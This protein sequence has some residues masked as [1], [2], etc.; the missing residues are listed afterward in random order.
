MDKN[1]ERKLEILSRIDDDIIE[2]QTKQRIFLMSGRK[3]KKSPKK[4][5]ITGGALAAAAAIILAM[6]LILVP[7]L[8]K[9]VPIYTGMTV[10]GELTAGQAS[11]GNV[12]VLELNG[13]GSGAQHKGHYQGDFNYDRGDLSN[14][15]DKPLSDT[16]NVVGGGEERYYAKPGEDIYITVHIDN[17][18]NFEILS[19]TLNGQKYSSYMFEEG[20][21]MENLILKVNVGNAEGVVEY[22]IDAIKYVDGNEIKDVRM[23]GDRTVE[24]GVYTENQPTAAVSAESIAYNS[25]SFT[26][27]ATDLMDL[28]KDSDG[29]L[30]AVLYDGNSI[31]A[32]QAIAAKGETRITFDGLGTNTLY[33]YAILATYDALDGQGISTYILA[34]KA[35]YTKAVVLFDHISLSTTGVNFAL[36]WDSAIT[37]QSLLDLSIYRGNTKVGIL[38]TSATTVSDLI[39]DTAYT[40]VATY[41]NG[42]GTETIRLE[43][44]TDP[45]TYT[46]NHLKEKLDGTYELVSTATDVIA[47]GAD[48]T[49]AVNAYTGFTSPATQTVTGSTEVALEVN[50]YYPRTAYT[51]TF[52]RNDG[53]AADT[54]SLKYGYEIP[55]DTRDYFGGW[56]TDETLTQLT[57]TVPATDVTLYAK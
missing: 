22:T 20:S 50:Y 3:K 47:F 45:L 15:F 55:G 44:T 41:R 48:I 37:D 54:L 19:F 29:K 57:Y 39:P 2:K 56:F 5:F 53:A 52:V 4:W 24:I 34:Q 23:E 38:D 35:F 9:Q 43:F 8:A 42:T 1:T 7:M 12:T 32:K 16:L 21:D 46:V 18:D 33:Q 13:E 31:V 17:P 26:V 11:T 40:L 10:S 6:V 27:T 14:P 30:E 51:L 36:D 28:V 49:P 25:I